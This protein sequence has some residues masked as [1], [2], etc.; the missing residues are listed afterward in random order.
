MIAEQMIEIERLKANQRC[1]AIEQGDVGYPC[2]FRAE[3][4]ARIAAL[5]AERADLIKINNARAWNHLQGVDGMKP[6]PKVL[7]QIADVVL[8]YRPKPK[9][10]PA[11]RRKRRAA[12]IAKGGDAGN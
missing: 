7:D 2:V 11:K 9:T 3:A 1:S 4:E 6:A 5:E 12:K 8:A 10:K